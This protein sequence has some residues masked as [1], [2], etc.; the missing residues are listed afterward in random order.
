MFKFELGEEV[1]ETVTGFTGIIMARS[2][3][4]TGCVHYG[5]VSK[6][7]NKEGIPQ[8]YQW[9]DTERLVRTGKKGIKFG[10]K[11]RSGIMPDPPSDG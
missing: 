6:K 11:P 4:F 10:G 2:E 7:L 5:L 3:Y 1:K 9:F 8:N